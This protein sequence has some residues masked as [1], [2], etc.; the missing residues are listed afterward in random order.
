MDAKVG[1]WV[2]TPR[3]GKPVEINAL[4]YNAL[5][6]MARLR[7]RAS[8]SRPTTTP[9][10]P[11]AAEPASAGSGTRDRLLLRRAR[12]PRRRRPGAPPQPDLCR[13]R[14][15]RP[16]PGARATARRR[17]R[18]RGRLLT[19]TACARRPGRPGLYGATAAT[20]R[21]RDGA[22]HQGT[23]WAWLIGPFVEAHL[24]RLRRRRRGRAI[25]EP[26][27]RPPSH[28][29]LGTVSEIFDGDPPHT[30]RGCIAQAW[31]VAEVA[32]RLAQARRTGVRSAVP[33]PS[34]KGR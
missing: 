1:D 28:E 32:A 10:W 6:V 20:H 30:P 22:Y 23:V 7:A 5:C 27:R 18:L 24:P 2:V 19:R 21:D 4:W 17:R 12:R 9:R 29:G 33:S 8:A 3:I 11:R 15:A 16:A 13:R 26:A 14:S 25:L 31:S 34:D